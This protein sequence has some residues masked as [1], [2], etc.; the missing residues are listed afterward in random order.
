MIATLFSVAVDD[1]RA[2]H[3]ASLFHLISRDAVVEKALNPLDADFTRTQLAHPRVLQAR[4]DARFGIKQLYRERGIAYPASEIFLRV[5][6]RERVLELWVRTAGG[7]RFQLLKDYRICALAGEIG[8]KREQGDNQTPEGFYE[9]DAFNP[10]SEY[11]LSLHVD[12]PNASDRVLGNR[13]ALG[14]SIYI[15]GGC[16]TIGCI[17]VTDE[18]IKELYWIAVEARAAGQPRIPVHIFPARLTENEMTVLA[19]SF[20]SRPDLM[21][22]WKNLKPGYE[23]FERWGLPPVMD[24]DASGRYRIVDRAGIRVTEP[25]TGETGGSGR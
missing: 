16:K 13:S 5:F 2:Q 19:G 6:K 18:A 20:S 3:S 24:V 22:F 9:I 14:G 15:H 11:L 21:T 4:I 23:Y 12:Y 17:A 25:S 8:P 7:Q 10:Q 1:A